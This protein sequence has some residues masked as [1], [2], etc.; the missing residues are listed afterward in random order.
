M[1]RNSRG[2]PENP[3]WTDADFARAKAPATLPDHVLA[4]FPK[5]PGAAAAR[6]RLMTPPAGKAI[7]AQGAGARF[8]AL[9]A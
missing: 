2:D 5:T 1:A 7:M 3:E 6:R 9:G 8:A 4:A